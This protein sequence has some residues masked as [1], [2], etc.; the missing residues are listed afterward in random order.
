M[1]L[2]RGHP[3]VG[4]MVTRKKTLLVGVERLEGAQK[5]GWLVGLKLIERSL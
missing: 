4:S 1:A 3:W 5:Q 2:G